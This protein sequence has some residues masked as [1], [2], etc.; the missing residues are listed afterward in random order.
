MSWIILKS[1][2]QEF[3]PFCPLTVHTSV[4]TTR[5]DGLCIPRK[6]AVGALLDEKHL[7][8]S[9]ALKHLE[10]AIEWRQCESSSDESWQSSSSE[11]F[12]LRL[13]ERASTAT[14]ELNHSGRFR[15]ASVL[16]RVN[17]ALTPRWGRTVFSF[18]TH[19]K[20]TEYK[21]QSQRAGW[22]MMLCIKSL[23][24]RHKIH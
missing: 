9:W 14:I 21:H 7:L 13:C 1:L 2:A 10:C 3:P 12:I 11:E 23:S 17:V 20:I 24:D 15:E 18:Y 19:S 5:Q 16:Q 22:L 6:H 8:F 4:R